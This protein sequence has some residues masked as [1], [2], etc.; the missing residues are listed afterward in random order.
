MT[1]NPVLPVKSV[2]TSYTATSS[3]SVIEVSGGATVTLPSPSSVTGQLFLIKNMD[4][5]N[6]AFIHVSL[7]VTID[8]QT[9]V[10]LGTLYD[11]ML[12]TSD[13]NNYLR[14]AVS[15]LS[16]DGV[17][18]NLFNTP[19]TG[20]V[21]TAVSS[22]GAEWLP[23]AGGATIDTT[24]TDIQP[25][26]T[27]AAG[28]TGKAADAS[29]VHPMPR[30]DQVAAPTSVV[31]MSGQK[32]TGMANG[33]A[34]TDAAT[35]GQLPVVPGSLPPNGAA[36]GDLAGTYPNP[37]VAQVNGLPVATSPGGTSDFL[38]ADGTW[39]VP[40]TDSTGVT[41]FN[42]RTGDVSLTKADVTGT[43][44][45]Y[46]D[47][48]ADAAGAASTAQSN[49]ETYAASQ[50]SAAQSAA[51]AA[52]DPAGSAASVQS[53]SLQKSANLSDLPST[54]TA[55][56]NL[57]L[58]SAALSNTS[59][60]DYSGAASA[61]QAASL[62]KSNDLSDLPDASAARGNLGLGSAATSSASAFDPAG[63]AS[64]AQSAAESY[65]SSLQAGNLQKSNN[66]SDLAS[67]ATAR[68]NL[69][70]GSAALQPSSAFVTAAND[71]WEGLRPCTSGFNGSITG[72]YPPQI[73]LSPDGTRVELFGIV[74]L[75]S[76]AANNTA[77][78]VNPVPTAYRAPEDM[79]MLS[80]LWGATNASVIVRAYAIDGTIRFFGLP[81]SPTGSM[82]VM[83]NC[84]YPISGLITS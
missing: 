22:A 76:T 2:S 61:A 62:Q 66:L 50:A 58:G 71:S 26:G 12:I 54:A 9:T 65:A 24:S 21:L 59:A 25:L 34:P 7:P 45:T 48:G 55:R 37:S 10:T 74:G 19:T 49:A 17:N 68:A 82:Y 75:S 30:L 72:N 78:F 42:T 47:V 32:L 6:E 31:A 8:G 27:Q 11:W 1:N 4:A 83:L 77:V 52:S 79:Y 40:P 16:S 51:E 15:G 69:G 67:P 29:H 73:R 14:V 53:A 36:G 38:R 43:G 35:V 18:V 5:G 84:S 56:A 80:V 81:S 57:G 23:P 70:L 46:T 39:A 28:S 63:S 64:S 60:F 44:L 41:S 13:G 20:T 33:S 3:D